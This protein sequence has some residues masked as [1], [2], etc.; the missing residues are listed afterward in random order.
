MKTTTIARTSRTC[1]TKKKKTQPVATTPINAPIRVFVK[2]YLHQKKEEENTE[3][4]FIDG[5]PTRKSPI[6]KWKPKTPEEVQVEQDGHLFVCNFDRIFD[7]KD[8]RKYRRFM[9]KKGSYENQ[10]DTITKY[11]NFFMNNYDARDQELANAYLKIKFETDRNDG[12]KKYSLSAWRDFLYETIFTP[13]M[14]DKII[15]MVEENYLD[16]IEKSTED[17]EKYLKNKKMHLE[18]L[19]FTNM[20]IKI[21]LRISFAMKIMSP[22]IFHYLA[23]SN[24]QIKKDSEI[25]FD[26][27]HKLFEIF[28]YDND[29]SLYEKNGAVISRG[30]RPSIVQ[31]RVDMGSLVVYTNGYETRYIDPFDSSYYELTPINMYNKLYVYVKAKVLE[32]NSNNSMIFEQRE[33]FGVDVY[34]VIK[35]FLKKVLISENIVKYKFNEHW[36]PKLKKYKENIVGLNK[37]I[38]KYQ[39][40]YFLKEQYQ[41]NITEVTNT[42]NSEG[43]SASDKMMMN[44]S[45]LNEGD[46]IMTDINLET[47]IAD[48]RKR[49]DVPITEEEIEYYRQNM[50]PSDLQIQ[51]LFSYYANEFK[52]FKD[53]NTITRRDYIILALLMKKKLLSESGY[54]TD[55]DGTVYPVALPYILTGNIKSEVNTRTIRNQKYLTK[56]KESYLYKNIME[57]KYR[58]LNEIAPDCIENLLSQF[59]NTDFTY[60]TYENPALTGETITYNEDRISDE[61]LFLVNTI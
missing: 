56:I 33:I 48:I 61:L 5:K 35:N 1:N 29:Y 27:Y 38:I 18:S 40:S 21:L 47:T 3:P 31:D 49:Y 45:K 9:I 44:M 54:R 43:L 2:G 32:S 17:K 58:T 25:I 42:K 37:T 14:V 8:L 30:I 55:E 12:Y 23:L 19:E 52:S 51:L 57:D 10:L 36:D 24:I 28:G 53:L 22:A 6:N 26:F 11:T 7:R 60:C 13:T 20:H 41:K 4:K 39:I 50:I 15:L 16:D 59:I 46:H 34:S